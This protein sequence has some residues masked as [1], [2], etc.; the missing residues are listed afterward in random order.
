[1]D[2][3]HKDH[4]DYARDTVI[5]IDLDA[6]TH[7]V[8]EF[9][10]H[11]PAGTKIMAAVKA[12][13]YGHGSIPVARAALEAGASYLAVAFVDEGVELRLGGIE[14]P[15]L[16]FG[17]TPDYA[18][19]Y[20]LKHQLSLTIYSLESLQAVEQAATLLGIQA[21]VHIKVDTGMGR[22]GVQPS[23][24]LT[25]IQAALKCKHVRVEGVFTHLATSDEPDQSYT[26]WQAERFA[27]VIKQCEE[28][29]IPIPLIHIANSGGAI[30]MP[31]LS[32]DMVRIGIS[33]YGC[34]PSA[35]VDQK[36]VCL[37]PV[38]TF[39]SKIVHLKQL[40]AGVGVS[41]GKTYVS[42]GDEWI[43]TIP[44]GYADGYSRS[45]SNRGYALVGGIRVPVIGRVCMD[46]LM[47]DVTEAMP[48]QVGDE[49]VLYGRQGDEQ[50]TLEEVADQI[51]TINYEVSC[52]LSHRVPRIYMRNGQT[53]EVVNRLQYTTTDV[54]PV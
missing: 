16:V 50:I 22:I 28:Q 39:K 42:S 49:V 14:A 48:V 36:K 4:L 45:L 30:E 25:L 38:L 17:Y 13:A 20:A 27:S 9:Q 29:E 18:V 52:M 41:Y 31:N 34:Y 11:L 46:Q 12:N 51:G 44:V 3:N 53:V 19:M 43:A 21:N 1:V 35:E 24:A 37:K 2:G 26:K 23:E 32:Y 10:Q 40:P 7:N 47:L 15:I 33:L 5:E 8:K 6:L 54:K